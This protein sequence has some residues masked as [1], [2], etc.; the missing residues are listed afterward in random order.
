MDPKLSCL[1]V[2]DFV[3]LL[4]FF[5][6]PLGG[7]VFKNQRPQLSPAP[8]FPKPNCFKK[9]EIVVIP[10]SRFLFEILDSSLRTFNS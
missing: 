1:L 4:L 3:L 2:F 8:S 6:H 9:E 7:G 5:V 10:I